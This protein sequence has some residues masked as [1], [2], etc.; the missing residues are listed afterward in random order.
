MIKSIISLLL[1]LFCN[2]LVLSNDSTSVNYDSTEIEARSFNLEKINEHK[3]DEDFDYGSR[4]KAEQSIWERIKIWF[5]RILSK[6]FYFGTNT[7]IGKILIYILVISAMA[8]ALYKLIKSKSPRPMYG[9]KSDDFP[10]SLH[11]ENIH[12]MDFD[13]LINKA[14]LKKEFRLAIR[15]IYLYALKH[16]ADQ[17]LIDW[18]VGK[19]NHEYVSE[20]KNEN[21]KKGFDELSYY[22]DYAWYGDFKVDEQLFNSVNSTFEKW[23]NNLGEKRS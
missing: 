23:K 19:T 12:E 17:E 3:A 2:T 8:Y 14:I 10:Y 20:L 21:V 15:L 7:P 5:Q 16:L 22:F 13:D 6:L 11:H 1:I 9:L 4:P 18:Q